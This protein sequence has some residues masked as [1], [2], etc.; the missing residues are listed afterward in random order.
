[1]ATIAALSQQQNPLGG[2]D[3]GLTH[4]L[5]NIGEDTQF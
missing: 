3:L 4:G 5:P 1:M 2:F